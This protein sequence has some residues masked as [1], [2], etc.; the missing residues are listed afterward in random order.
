M[1]AV[2]EG[3]EETPEVLA[4]GVEGSFFDSG[5]EGSNTPAS[6]VVAET[7]ALSVVERPEYIM[8]QHWDPVKGEVRI[9]SLAKSLKDTKAALDKKHD[10][11]GMPTY[12]KGYFKVDMDG[13]L[14]LPEG[15]DN[16]PQIPENDELLKG[17]AEAA[18]EADMSQKQFDAMTNQYFHYM[19]KAISENMFDPERVIREVSS[20]PDIARNTVD[21]C[22]VYLNS[23]GLTEAETHA[24]TA[25]MATSGG[26]LLLSKVMDARGIRSVP[27]GASYN[28]KGD[29]SALMDEWNALRADT[30]GLQS[31]PGKRQRFEELGLKL[32]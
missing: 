25:I 26:I 11:T 17:M 9:E 16:L 19:D 24:A 1:E 13:N 29:N 27:L 8:E 5:E 18:H 6:T 22:N 14:V 7:E 21:G 12:A 10:D 31:D 15:L 28:P 2:A 32:F 4:E 20:D 30:N 3:G 23:L